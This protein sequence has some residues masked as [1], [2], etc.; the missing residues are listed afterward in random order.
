MI[1]NKK[2]QMAPA[3]YAL[4]FIGVVI[5]LVW[6]VSY[7]SGESNTNG[8]SDKISN[9]KS[10]AELT[11]VESL[12]FLKYF[13][14]DIPSGLVDLTNGTSAVIIVIVLFLMLL[15]TFGDI[16][17]AF[18]AFSKSS[19]WLLGAGLAIIAAN[20]KVIMI[21]A[22]WSF[23]IV[24]GFGVVSVAV[25][26]LVPFVVFFV[27]NVLLLKQLKH[28]RNLTEMKTGAEGVAGA[29]EGFGKAAKAFRTA[30]KAEEA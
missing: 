9:A 28:S 30:A 5:L 7:F 19:A 2:A 3:L 13:F 21:I 6:A 10:I 12:G 1:K 27:L 4:L 16:L 22:V 20:L 23:G 17:S 14:G 25:G 8:I 11:G 18:G 15:I 29:I 26:L 24:A